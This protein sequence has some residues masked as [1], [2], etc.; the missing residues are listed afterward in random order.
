MTKRFL[1]FTAIVFSM[2]IS[3]HTNAFSLSCGAPINW[4]TFNHPK[5]ELGKYHK[6]TQ[7]EESVIIKLKGYVYYI[8]ANHYNLIT[9]CTPKLFVI[10]IFFNDKY[11][12]IQL[13]DS[14]MK[15]LKIEDK[16][17]DCIGKQVQF[18]KPNKIHLQRVEDSEI[19]DKDDVEI[20][21]GEVVTKFLNSENLF[22]HPQNIKTCEAV[23]EGRVFDIPAY[24]PVGSPP[25]DIGAIFHVLS[26]ES[27]KRVE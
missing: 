2:I 24:I 20:L 8:N 9:D 13:S 7:N 3:C 17:R 18:N 19:S 15:D 11:Q 4:Q 22:P 21:E 14:G 10:P 12:Y 5:L 1:K 25:M 26:I 6:L 16:I 27:M 23:L